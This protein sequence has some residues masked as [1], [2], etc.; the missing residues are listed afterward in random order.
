MD[1]RDRF[2][3]LARSP[4][5][6]QVVAA[7]RLYLSATVNDPLGTEG[8]R[9]A[10]SCLPTTNGNSRFSCVSM[11]GME[12]FVVLKPRTEDEVPRAFVVVSAEDLDAGFADPKLEILPTHYESG[13]DDQL[14]VEGS[15]LA[16]TQ[17]LAGK[18]GRP[19][20][21]RRAARALAA[22]LLEHDTSYAR[23]HNSDLAGRVLGRS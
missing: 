15:L 19:A 9:W 7:N 6:D 10:L 8:G 5:F 1:Q 18:P 20:P 16:V 11:R 22:Y 14:H 2:G 3:E 21:L 17:A 13:P 4:Y 12:T 23:Y